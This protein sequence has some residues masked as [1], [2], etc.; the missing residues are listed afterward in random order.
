VS[1]LTDSGANLTKVSF[2]NL[3]YVIEASSTFPLTTFNTSYTYAVYVET[4]EKQVK[5]RAYCSSSE[6]TALITVQSPDKALQKQSEII[7]F[8]EI[9][10]PFT[11][12]QNNL[13][14]WTITVS[15]VPVKPFED[16]Q[17]YLYDEEFPYLMTTN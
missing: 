14:F 10:M 15:P 6:E 4:E 16:L 9:K 2:S 1:L 7:E 5:L 17:F 3:P 12:H 8:T 11:V 13:N